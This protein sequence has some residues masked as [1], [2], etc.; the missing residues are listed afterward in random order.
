MLEVYIGLGSN[1]G[2]SPQILLTALADMKKIPQYRELKRSGLWLSEPIG[3]PVQPDYCNAV[4]KAAYSGTPLQLLGQL[5]AIEQHYG[6]VR[7]EVNG[8]RTLDL[9]ILLFGKEVIADPQLVVPHPRL[10]QRAF[11]LLPLMQLDDNLIIPGYGQTPGQLYSQLTPQR[12]KQW[13]IFGA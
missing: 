11:V 5:Q 12:I 2:D 4:V 6:R 10:A 8:P 1:L 3:G 7:A 13:D 9:D